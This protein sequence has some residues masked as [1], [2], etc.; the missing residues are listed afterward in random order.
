MLFNSYIFIF[1]FLPI[2]LCGWWLL[3]GSKVRLTFVTLASYFFYGWWNW[4]FLPLMIAS[5]TV[6]Y[7]AGN[8]IAKSD[9]ERRR[10]AW[11]ACSLAFNLSILGFFK[12]CNFFI[13]TLNTGLHALHSPD[14]ISLL[15]IILPIGISFY[16]FNSMSYT[17]D[18]YRGIVRPAPSPLH[19]SAFVALFPHLIAGPIVRYA[20]VGDQFL[21]LKTRLSNSQAAT[22]IF[23]FVA[24]MVK[25][26]LIADRFAKGAD[27]FFASPLGASAST[28]WTGVLSYTFQ[29]YFDFSAYSDMAVGIAHLMGI[30]F[31]QNFASP[32]KAVNIADF[33][34]RWHISLSSWLRDYLFIPLGGSR[35]TI[36]QTARNLTITMFLGGLW[37][38][39]SWTFV[40]WGLYHGILLGGHATLRRLGWTFGPRI[41]S[42]I[43]TFLFV[44]VGWVFFRATT[45][46]SAIS[47]FRGMFGLNGFWPAPGS[48]NSLIRLI[49]GASIVFLMPNTWQIKF[50]PRLSL[51]YGMAVAVMLAILMLGNASPFLYFQF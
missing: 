16:T 5:T 11:L 27:S 34:R 31:P 42:Q 37:H 30:Q 39:A 40:V 15:H 24:G 2:V 41:C 38:G 35:G 21:N 48:L 25:K 4:H 22:G 14:S 17:I 1:A 47:V 33:W 13:N 3:R 23:F 45:F 18:I 46:T 12:Y 49:A 10:K 29:I 6:D 43:A 51:A 9:E 19:F 50:K 28:A 26:V 36:L 8:L 7:I 20:D 44:V 32:Y